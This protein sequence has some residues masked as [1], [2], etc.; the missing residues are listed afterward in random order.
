MLRR[1]ESEQRRRV[2]AQRQQREEL[3]EQRRL[4]QQRLQREKDEQHQQDATLF[5]G[6]YLAGVSD[7]MAEQVSPQGGGSSAR[8]QIRMMPYVPRR[9]PSGGGVLGGAGS[10]AA[11]DRR[12]RS[13]KQQ[14]YMR[15]LE[16]QMQER[17]A[18]R[19]AQRAQ[20]DAFDRRFEKEATQFNGLG[21]RR[22]RDV[23]AEPSGGGSG[24]LASDSD[25][26]AVHQPS[27]GRP[28]PPPGAFALGAGAATGAAPGAGL[29]WRPSRIT[30]PLD[31]LGLIQGGGGGGGRELALRRPPSPSHGPVVRGLDQDAHL[32]RLLDWERDRARERELQREREQQHAREREERR[33]VMHDEATQRQRLWDQRLREEEAERHAKVE[34]AM[35]GEIAALRRDI[36]AQH[37]RL[38]E[39][40]EAQITRLRHARAASA[41]PRPA[42]ALPPHPPALSTGSAGA[43]PPVAPPR[44][45]VT[46]RESSSGASY[47]AGPPYSA[48]PTTSQPPPI[49]G[50]EAY[51]AA[52]REALRELTGNGGMPPST[53]PAPSSSP[54][55]LPTAAAPSGPRQEAAEQDELD[56]LLLDFLHNGADL[57]GS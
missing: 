27:A 1:T 50:S 14:A 33:Q 41:E 55:P 46:A 22:E 15:E 5:G 29:H 18:R 16:Q 38:A 20:D 52:A 45:G 39:E 36:L 11:E 30:Q 28:V 56:K 13:E 37:R 51:E 49:P 44:T 31:D 35:A 47:V 7:E 53:A 23:A 21:Q 24:R 4:K 48:A 57:R 25:E 34:R 43:Y 12:A 42:Y 6:R 17:E 19:A 26:G 2:E 8:G 9:P 40:V 32:G 10:Q 3:D 54:P